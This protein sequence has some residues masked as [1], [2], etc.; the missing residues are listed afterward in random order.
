M[1]SLEQDKVYANQLYFKDNILVNNSNINS[2]A[3]NYGMKLRN[4]LLIINKKNSN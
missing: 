2:S 4:N 3:F 1:K